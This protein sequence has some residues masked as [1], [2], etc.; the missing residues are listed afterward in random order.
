MFRANDK[1]TSIL[2]LI[3]MIEHFIFKLGCSNSEKSLKEKE[4][5]DS[6][7]EDHVKPGNF[8]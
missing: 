2:E 1:E 7:S 8:P 4:N 5:A 6:R 3:F